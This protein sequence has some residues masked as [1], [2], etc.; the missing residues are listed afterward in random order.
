MSSKLVFQDLDGTTLYNKDILYD[1]LAPLPMQNE[2]VRLP[3]GQQ[4]TVVGRQIV[5]VES[6]RE[7]TDVH[8]IFVCE[9]EKEHKLSKSR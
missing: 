5:Y 2:R 6:Q 3:D 4:I 8:V 9:R 7:E 1:G